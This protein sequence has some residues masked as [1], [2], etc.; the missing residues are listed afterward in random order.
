[1]I[2]KVN[3]PHE[4]RF[5]TVYE[6]ELWTNIPRKMNLKLKKNLGREVKSMYI[7]KEYQPEYN[8][9]FEYGKKR[10]DHG[11]LDF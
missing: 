8:P 9:N 1:M 6:S 10:I 4:E 5:K 2:N 11:I 3:N 7:N